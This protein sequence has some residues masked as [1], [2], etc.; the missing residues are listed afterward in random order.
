VNAVDEAPA[1]LDAPQ[2]PV[3]TVT[4]GSLT[5]AELAAVLAVLFAAGAARAA[6]APEI[7][8]PPSAWAQRSRTRSPLPPPGPGA[9]RASALPY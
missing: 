3:V 6:A 8:A 5:P 9:W 2:S 4:R 7:P 1:A